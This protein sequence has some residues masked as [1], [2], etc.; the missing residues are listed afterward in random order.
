MKTKTRPWRHRQPRCVTLSRYR[1]TRC[2][3]VCPNPIRR[4]LLM[5]S[6]PRLTESAASSLP[7]LMP[8]FEL[9]FFAYGRR[10]RPLPVDGYLCCLIGTLPRLI[11]PRPCTSVSTAI[12]KTP[13]IRRDR[14]SWI[15]PSSTPPAFR[16]Q[17]LVVLN[18]PVLITGISGFPEFESAP[19]LL[20]FGQSHSSTAPNLHFAQPAPRIARRPFFCRRSCI[21]DTRPLFDT[22]HIFFDEFTARRN[23]IKWFAMTGFSPP[24]DSGG[25]VCAVTVSVSSRYHT[26]RR[27]RCASGSSDSFR[28]PGGPSVRS[29][30]LC[31]FRT[32]DRIQSALSVRPGHMLPLSLNFSIL[33]DLASGHLARRWA[34]ILHVIH[35]R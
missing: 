25:I 18:G 4:R 35:F 1:P 5:R 10:S 17:L 13:R 8:R 2:C 23:A 3:S 34:A 30:V 27:R 21:A 12:S 28:Q 7:P 11:R 6:R 19:I 9:V 24:P 20:A 22:L 16:S 26:Y 32:V 29:I 14:G 31:G 15:I 33:A